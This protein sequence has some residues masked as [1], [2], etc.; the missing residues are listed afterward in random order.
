MDDDD[1][2][3]DDNDVD[4]SPAKHSNKDNMKK[5]PAG[6]DDVNLDDSD[7]GQSTVKKL[8]SAVH[9]EFVEDGE[10]PVE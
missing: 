3:D 10:E 4:N 6:F 5:L 7:D 2:E 1:D 8:P 9:E